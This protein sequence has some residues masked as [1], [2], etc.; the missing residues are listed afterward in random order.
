MKKHL[1][2]TM[3]GTILLGVGSELYVDVRTI[4]AN[5]ATATQVAPDGVVSIPDANL[6]SEI[7]KA[8]GKDAEITPEN[9]AKITAL[10]LTYSDVKDL[11]GLSYAKN[12]KSLDLS[13]NSIDSVTELS[14]LTNLRFLSLRFNKADVM[15]DL[16]PLKNTGLTELNL[17]AN[18][19]GA[20]QQKLDGLNT[21]SSLETIE[22]S[23]NKLTSLPPIN[24]LKNLRSLGLGGNKLTDISGLAGMTGLKTLEINSNQ[25][26]NFEPISHL[27]NLERLSLGNNRTS[28]ISSLK[29]LVN[30][31]KGG[32]SQLGLTNAQ[33][34]VFANMKQLEI[35]AIDFNDQISDLS[36]LSGLVQMKDLNFSKD[37]VTSIEPLT[38]MTQ[39]ESLGFSD[40]DISDLTPLKNMSKLSS[41]VM[42]RNHVSD[43]SPIQ[44]LQNIE[45]I[46]AKFQKV[47]LPK[48][49]V[50][51]TE[52]SYKVPAVVKSRLNNVLPL[53]LQTSGQLKMVDGGVELT[54]VDIK[55]DP[56]AF[57][58]WT[59]D[60]NDA[61][62]KFTGNIDQ[63]FKQKGDESKKDQKAVKIS[64][65]KGDGSN[66]TSVAS[67][68]IQSDA[69]IE[70]QA[71]GK[72]TLLMKV[73]VP[74]TYGEDSITFVNGTKVSS[75]TVGE[76]INLEY[77]FN[78]SDD[79][80]KGNAF[81]ENMHVK[82][83][84]EVLNYDHWYDVFIKINGLNEE[85]KNTKPNETDKPSA[86][87]KSKDDTNKSEVPT[88]V[89]EY[90]TYKAHYLKHNTSEKSTMAQFMTDSAKLYYQDGIQFVEISAKDQKSADMISRM[91]LNGQNSVKREGNKFYFNLGKQKLQDD[92]SVT[93]DGFVDVSTIIPGIG[94]FKEQQPFTLELDGRNF[95]EGTKK[96]EPK[97][98][99]NKIEVPTKVDEYATYKAHY[100]KHNTS[101][102][103]TMAQFMTDGAKLYYQDDTQYVE[104]AAKDQKSAD[105]IARMSL[106]GQ[107]S[108]KREGNKFYFNLGKQKLQDEKS[109]TLD[110]FVVVSTTIP[111]IGE[112]KE[113]QPFTLQLDGRDFH[114]NK[115]EEQTPK[116]EVKPETKPDE[117]NKDK[118]PSDKPAYVGYKAHYLKY[119]T[120]DKSTMAQ[121]MTENAKLYYQDGNQ[122]VEIEAKDD[123]S[124][125]MISSMTLNKVNFFKRDGNTYYF[126]LGKQKL[127]DKQSIKLDGFVVV[128]TTIPGMGAF[129]EE[130]PFTLQLD[131][132]V[133]QSDKNE[134]NTKPETKPNPEVKPEPKPEVKPKPDVKPNESNKDKAPSNKTAYVGYKAHYLKHGT[135]NKSTMAQFMSADAKLYYQDGNQYIEISAKDQK[136]ADMISRMTLNNTN[137]FKHVGNKYYFNLGKQKLQD[138][139]SIKLDGFV[140]VSTN[141]PGIGEFKE[142]QP[143][144]L[145]LNGRQ[146]HEGVKEDR[147]TG[148]SHKTPT[149]NKKPAPKPQANRESTNQ[150]K[151]KKPFVGNAY[152]NYAAQYLKQGTNQ[153]SVMASYMMNAAHVEIKGNSA[154]ITIFAKDIASANMM[155]KLMLG[156]KQAVRSGNGY[157][158]TL[159]KSALN[160]IIN[161]HVDVDV[162]GIIKE[163][164]PFSL[165]LTSGFDGTPVAGDNNEMTM[166]NMMNDGVVNGAA[167]PLL[168]NAA[169]SQVTDSSATPVADKAAQQ[170]KQSKTNKNDEPKQIGDQAN[171][172]EQQTPKKAQK[173]NPVFI[174]VGGI[175]ATVLGF[176]GTVV[177]WKIFKG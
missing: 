152:Y 4:S 159:P 61:R 153:T 46:N 111:G 25:I 55:K 102:Q 53:T 5:A 21:I 127:Q 86:E 68:F 64:V 98:N 57:M 41:I 130:Q 24:H 121:F 30:L 131:G 99:D 48:M 135:S 88:N 79:A 51:G 9:M 33:M 54:A 106:N 78:L 142:E 174:V 82:I 83:N 32:F 163:S 36:S 26:T 116:P 141:L 13:G 157:T 28:D 119:N 3:L 140:V 89:D 90:A 149:P 162:P 160:G 77:R 73:I 164:Q 58:S 173:Q 19:Y 95:H 37:S 45:R 117:S 120:S 124:A 12:L 172:A 72:K 123:K 100:L 39:M 87:D 109:V 161:G 151:H 10:N 1:V 144:T 60:A 176:I 42:L 110:G 80:L 35:L 47:T 59:S 147:P 128:S 14:G 8:L 84:P 143:F 122:Y 50:D 155:T 40:N 20:D 154:V 66:L 171:L 126:N 63:P 134:G 138:K 34:P 136:S 108:V 6:R 115:K 49:T 139:Q 29:S 70:N 56:N 17:V 97:P 175:I 118:T 81:K 158:V 168:G 132:R 169:T 167:V 129:K 133:S 150:A 62:V 75:K 15:P 165:R 112:F 104:I 101:N 137:Y 44:N 107:N 18:E 145:Q 113:E 71:D 27:T 92:K 31:K 65:L 156:G 125:N 85:D 94:P 74:K 67:N 22:L 170:A 69:Y 96:D 91:S 23:G 114:T 38:G 43:L 103:S 52:K 105:M 93:L 2:I 16:T 146:V 7:Q 76:S 177:G 11:T 166:D 148:E